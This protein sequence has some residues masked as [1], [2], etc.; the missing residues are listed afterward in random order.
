MPLGVLDLAL[1][2][3]GQHCLNSGKRAADAV[4]IRQHQLGIRSK[5]ECFRLIT[6][7]AGPYGVFVDLREPGKGG[8]EVSLEHLDHGKVPDGIRPSSAVSQF[9]ADTSRLFEE[10]DGPRPVRGSCPSDTDNDPDVRSGRELSHRIRGGEGP[11]SIEVSQF[12]R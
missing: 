7:I 9:S 5:A 12:P 11:L 10:G 8:A 1:Q 4:E 6:K 3:A 2:A